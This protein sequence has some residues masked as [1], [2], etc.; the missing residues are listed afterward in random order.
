MR[1][2]R[3]NPTNPLAADKNSTRGSA[4]EKNPQAKSKLVSDEMQGRKKFYELEQFY[5]TIAA[6]LLQDKGRKSLG[7]LVIKLNRNLVENSD[8]PKVSKNE[9]LQSKIGKSVMSI[10]VFMEKLMNRSEGKAD[11]A[12]SVKLLDGFVSKLGHEIIRIYFDFEDMIEKP[13]PGHG[14]SHDKTFAK[15]DP[16]NPT[17][18]Q[19]PSEKADGNPTSK[20]EDKSPASGDHHPKSGFINT[21]HVSNM[22]ESSVTF[23]KN[24]KANSMSNNSKKPKPK[25]SVVKDSMISEKTE[26]MCEKPGIMTEKPVPN[27]F[28]EKG[29]TR[30]GRGIS[31]G[32]FSDENMLGSGADFGAS[33]GDTGKNSRDKDLGRGEALKIKGREESKKKGD[34]AGCGSILVKPGVS[35]KKKS[36]KGGREVRRESRSVSEDKKKSTKTRSRSRSRGS[37]IEREKDANSK[38]KDIVDTAKEDLASPKPEPAEDLNAIMT[39]NS[40]PNEPEPVEPINDYTKMVSD[41]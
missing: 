38:A 21:N 4:P 20:K 28:I 16:K 37:S 31:Y 10:K 30:S 7:R 35:K 17:V 6:D 22:S 39:E 14:R 13:V 15:D 24:L 27:M 36:G 3:Q 11:I 18:A 26:I 12:Q 33:S 1:E 40:P 32:Y 5:K 41:P 19:T 9:L 23:D 34:S 29:Y 8:I 2:N 25:E